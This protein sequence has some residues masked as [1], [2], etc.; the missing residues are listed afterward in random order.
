[1]VAGDTLYVP[2]TQ[3]LDDVLHWWEPVAHT[4]V[5]SK[6]RQAEEML[7][8]HPSVERVVGHSLGAS[9]AHE[10][11]GKY[12]KQYAGFGRPV[13]GFTDPGD[14]L[15]IGDPVGLFGIGPKRLALGHSLSSY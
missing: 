2:G 11:A 8:S 15:N 13:F 12:H 1:M 14:R 9:Y 10:L 7:R 6:Y 3:S 5:S 4:Y